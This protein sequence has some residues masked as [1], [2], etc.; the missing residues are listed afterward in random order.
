MRSIRRVLHVRIVAV[1]ALAIA[2]LVA[3]NALLFHPAFERI[4]D[5]SGDWLV[6]TRETMMVEQ[7][8]LA[9]EKIH[10]Y[11]EQPTEHLTLVAS[12]AQRVAEQDKETSDD[13]QA[14]Q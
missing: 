9:R 11:F 12:A 14:S 6:E 4:V 8:R 10:Q 3:G 13:Y 5:I 2:A 1:A 7:I